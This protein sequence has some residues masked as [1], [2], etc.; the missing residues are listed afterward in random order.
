MTLSQYIREIGDGKAG[1]IFGVSE[2]TAASWRRGERRP[3][4]EAARRIVA[5]SNGLLTLDVIYAGE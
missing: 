1:E 2:R 5:A 3:R 4:P